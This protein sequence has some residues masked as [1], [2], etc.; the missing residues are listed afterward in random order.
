MSSTGDH[1][2]AQHAGSSSMGGSGAGTSGQ[3]GG[4][5]G[6]GG[7]GHGGATDP[8]LSNKSGQSDQHSSGG[9]SLFS[10]A[11]GSSKC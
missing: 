2:K 10:S 6:T 3:S 4:I 11:G 8:G 1:S 7:Q 5:G 9:D